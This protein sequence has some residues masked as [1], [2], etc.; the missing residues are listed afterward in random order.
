[1]SKSPTYL[2]EEFLE[3]YQQIRQSSPRLFFDAQK[4]TT[5]IA[6]AS[7]K[8]YSPEKTWTYLKRL[9]ELLGRREGYKRPSEHVI[10]L[11][12]FAKL[13]K[14]E[15][16]KNAM[17]FYREVLEAGRKRSEITDLI[18]EQ[19]KRELNSKLAP[20]EK[21]ED[22]D[23]GTSSDL[24]RDIA[25]DIRDLVKNVYGPM[26]G[27]PGADSA[28]GVLSRFTNF[29]VSDVDDDPEPDA[30]ILYTNW[31]GSKK[32]SG[33]VNDGSPE[34]KAKTRELMADF[35]SKPGAWC[36]VSGAPAN[37]ALTKLDIPAVEDE[38]TVRALLPAIKDL[39]WHGEHP[40]GVSYGNGWYTRSIAGHDAT[41]IIIGNPTIHGSLKEYIEEVAK[42]EAD[43]DD[44]YG[45]YL[46]APGR[47]DLGEEE[48]QEEDTEEEDSLKV[49]LF[50]HYHGDKNSGLD[51][52]AQEVL[53]LIKQNK[54][55]K[56]LAPPE[57]KAVYRVLGPI[58]RHAAQQI[59]HINIMDIMEAPNT[60]KLASG[61]FT[62]LPQEEYSIQSWSTALKASWIIDD[63]YAGG[64]IYPEDF[65]VYV[66]VKSNTNNGS[67]FMNPKGIKNVEGM[68][69]YAYR[70]DEVISYGDVSGCTASYYFADHD[71]AQGTRNYMSKK[72][73]MPAMFTSLIK[74]AK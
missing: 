30:G 32:A 63:L 48:K 37:I 27:M 11:F 68:P 15:E 16:R 51:Q 12:L 21:G 59:L 28:T 3:L 24:A 31:G 42:A 18:K 10:G 58:N 61:R 44:L 33:I 5:L 22:V 56:I 66:V 4:I 38:E 41:K 45:K 9:E 57:S 47:R 17:K 26:G 19:L 62:L 43:E 71:K 52:H 8:G 65:M 70:Q 73:S 14:T 64:D 53:N 29:L 60:A 72:H 34:S 6:K 35:F 25:P 7:S 46:F 23:V 20:A 1:M 2:N 74:V 55:K 69:D 50:N 13:T 54:Y 40:R 36:E 39:V 67:F 49:A